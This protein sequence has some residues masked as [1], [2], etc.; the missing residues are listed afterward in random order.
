[1]LQDFRRQSLLLSQNILH[2]WDLIPTHRKE[3][4]LPDGVKAT[5]RP[6]T[7]RWRNPIRRMSFRGRLEIL[8]AVRGIA[9][10]ETFLLAGESLAEQLEA[11]VIEQEI[12]E[13]KWV[14]FCV[15]CY[16]NAQPLHPTVHTEH[17]EC[18]FILSLCGVTEI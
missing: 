7:T 3:E 10:R 15:S 6:E 14:L 2:I 18:Y 11:A 9:G 8:K 4:L 5:Q 1:M 12:E 16:Y 13:H 17:H